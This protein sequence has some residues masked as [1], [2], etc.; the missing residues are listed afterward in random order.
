MTAHLHCQNQVAHA[1]HTRDFW[2]EYTFPI[3]FAWHTHEYPVTLIGQDNGYQ[4]FFDLFCHCLLLNSYAIKII[5]G[6]IFMWIIIFMITVQWAGPLMFLAP[7][8]SFNLHVGHNAPSLVELVKLPIT[9][10]RSLGLQLDIAYHHLNTIQA[11]NAQYPDSMQRCVAAVFQTWLNK[12]REASYEKVEKAL[13]AAGM[14]ELAQQFF[15]QPG[16]MH[17]LSISLF[18]C[19][20]L[21]SLCSI[22]S[23]S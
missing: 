23:F 3:H 17:F 8:P 14:P 7:I 4:T 12:D 13:C 21:C 5:L 18:V 9:D 2:L 16:E 22:S 10:W 15:R 1:L 19:V 11:N 6:S 20:N